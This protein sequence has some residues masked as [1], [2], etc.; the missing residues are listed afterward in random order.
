[1]TKAELA[2]N[3]N[4]RVQAINP[5]T[6]GTNVGQIVSNIIAD[7]VDAYVKDMTI[8]ITVPA[9]AVSNNSTSEVQL[10]A[11]IQAL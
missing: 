8:T 5:M 11:T 1:M 7:E 10:T 9:L 6:P 3:I 2:T 4:T